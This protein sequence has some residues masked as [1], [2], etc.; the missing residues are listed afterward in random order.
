M[1][2]VSS[3]ETS[4][5]GVVVPIE[6]D[7]LKPTT[8]VTDRVLMPANY[9]HAA[10]QSIVSGTPMLKFDDGHRLWVSGQKA[11]GS[12]NGTEY[13]GANR[14]ATHP[15][16]RPYSIP[17]HSVETGG[18]VLRHRALQTP[19]ADSPVPQGV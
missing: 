6:G 18:C 11:G 10:A 9:L 19:V 16:W 15:A 8:T 14:S 7:P 4:V 12:F 3:F 17:R 13:F 5:K 2:Q 1:R